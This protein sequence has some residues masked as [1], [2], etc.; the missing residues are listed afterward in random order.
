MYKVP[1]RA[2]SYPAASQERPS[3]CCR[4]NQ[5][6]PHETLSQGDF[7]SR[8]PVSFRHVVSLTSVKVAERHQRGKAGRPAN[9]KR[10]NRTITV[11]QPHQTIDHIFPPRRKQKKKKTGKT[12]LVSWLADRRN[13]TTAASSRSSFTTPSLLAFATSL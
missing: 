12:S 9:S 5:H 10:R 3:R 1:D 6:T 4:S 8:F 2:E 13:D 7:Q 11:N